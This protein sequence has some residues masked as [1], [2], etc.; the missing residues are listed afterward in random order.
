MNLSFDIGQ[1]SRICIGPVA[2][3]LPRLAPVTGCFVVTDAEVQRCHPSLGVAAWPVVQIGRGEA[4][5][6]L[7]TIEEVH[8]RLLAAGADRSSFVVGIGGGIVTDVAGFAAATYM[9]GVPFGFVA[10]TLLA[11]VDA[12]IGGKNGVN[13]DGY[14][15]M[16]G[17]FTQPRFVVCDPALTATLPDREFRAGLAEALKAALVGDRTL[18]ELIEGVSYE[19]LRS[20]RELLTQVVARAVGV[21][22]GIVN[23]DERE[24]GERRKLNLGH[25]L[26]HAI[27]KCSDVM[28][29][30]EA[31]AVGTVLVAQAAVHL[32]RL[33]ATDCRRI[34]RVFEQLGFCLVPPV[35]M[36]RLLEVVAAD[37]KCERGTLHVVLPTSVGSCEVSDLPLAEFRRLMLTVAA[38]KFGE[39]SL[40]NAASRTEEVLE[41][42]VP[43][44]ACT[45]WTTDKGL[46]VCIRP[47]RGAERALLTEFLYE[48]IHCPEGTAPL[49]RTVIQHPDLWRYVEAFGHGEFDVAVVAEIDGTVVGAAWVRRM[50]GYGFVDAWTPEL[51]M[52]LY[53]PWRGQGIG[54]ELLRRLLD[55]VHRRGVDRVSLSVQRTN[56]AVRLYRRAGF[57]TWRESAEELILI[58]TWG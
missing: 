55:E 53:A 18:F 40:Q 43:A 7:Q 49:P 19:T 48:A 21:K 23:R 36:D 14:K 39:K 45:D 47:L 26:A 51:C 17:T 16:A 10:T 34:E 13:V 22:V 4:C 29:H 44:F 52:A 33:S 20:D 56:P 37:K 54:T 50:H 6:T 57:V 1:R 5:K 11:Q 3:W 30:G 27:E 9:R 35:P 28:N 31:V 41:E 25:T 32:G 38:E 12:A 24:S 46:A 15:N 42:S 2:E 58:R 8:R